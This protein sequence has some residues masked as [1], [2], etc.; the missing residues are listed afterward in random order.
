MACIRQIFPDAEITP[1]CV[2]KYPIRV[3][4][5]AHV[6]AGSQKS[7]VVWQGDQRALFRKY[8]SRRKAA[9]EEIARRLND[10]KAEGL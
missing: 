3:V 10:L 2:D 1:K 7:V 9:Q 4:I 6:A 5:E 8:A